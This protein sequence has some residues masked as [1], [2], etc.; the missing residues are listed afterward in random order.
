MNCIIVANVVIVMIIGRIAF[1]RAISWQQPEG[2]IIN[3]DILRT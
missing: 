1:G 2:L 3:R